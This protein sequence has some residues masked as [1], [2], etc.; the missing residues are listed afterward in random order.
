MS[1]IKYYITLLDHRNDLH[2]AFFPLGDKTGLRR[3]HGGWQL[4]TFG[5]YSRP[6]LAFLRLDRS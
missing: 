6:S 3:F 4:R 1:E 2:G 5:R